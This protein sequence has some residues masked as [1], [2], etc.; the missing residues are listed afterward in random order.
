MRKKKTGSTLAAPASAPVEEREVPMSTNPAAPTTELSSHDSEVL[1]NQP[2]GQ[3][4][5]VSSSAVVSAELSGDN[6]H[7]H[8]SHA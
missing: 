6:V 1:H 8:A 7:H 2:H 3:S 5:S 4:H